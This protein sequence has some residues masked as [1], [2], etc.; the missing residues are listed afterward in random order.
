VPAASMHVPL[1]DLKAQYAAI[2]GEIRAAIDSV[3]DSQH[4]VLGAHVSSLETELACYSGAPYAVGVAS[5]SDALLLALMAIGIGPGDEVI[6]TPYTFFAT[7]AAVVRLGGVPVFVD[8]EPRTF[9]LAVEQVKAQITARTKAI[10][11]VHLYG[12]CADMAPLLAIAQEHG[13]KV[14]EDAAQA[15]GARYLSEPSNSNQDEQASTWSHAG[16]MG[17]LGCLSFYPSKACG[18][19]GDAGMVL[20]RDQVL[21]ERVR[22]LR[23][24][25]GLGKYRHDMVGVN[26]R[27]DEIQAAVL[28]VKLRYLDGWIAARQARA[29]RYDQL[30]QQAN[31]AGTPGEWE[32]GQAVG[33]PVVGPRRTHIFYVYAIRVSQRDRLSAYLSEHGVGTD[34]YYPVPLHV[35]PCFAPLGYRQGDFPE[36]E[37][38]AEESLALPMYPELSETQQAYVVEQIAD[39]YASPSGR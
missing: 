9:N 34:V 28:G 33:L 6:T 20:A 31:L 21:A 1:L 39:F 30:F 11:P 37:R 10:I 13:L 8:I 29:A 14:V 22:A 12:Q 38:A 5:G 35:Q 23:T 24:H 25:G 36:A 17:D 16:T 18:A 2:R 15:I 26:S 3:L 19:Y 7:A 4:F 27:L 32:P